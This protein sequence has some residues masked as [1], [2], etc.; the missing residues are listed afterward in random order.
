MQL[1]KKLHTP[2][3]RDPKHAPEGW[4]TRHLL[5]GLS[6]LAVLLLM[7]PPA[8][9]YSQ[10]ISVQLADREASAWVAFVFMLG[11]LAYFAKRLWAKE[12]YMATVA[13]ALM[14]GCLATIAATNPFSSTH[15]AAFAALTLVMCGL[16]WG[17]YWTHENV[18]LFCLSVLATGAVG[19]CVFNLGL[20]ERLLVAA[21]TM[22][23]NVVFYEHMA[24]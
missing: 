24:Y 20:G 17:L 13:C 15:L 7:V 1:R 5:A 6:V 16:H 2:Y 12:H 19:L 22:C 23:I 11:A 4:L 18:K 8:R 3:W 10:P 14:C 9:G 21:S